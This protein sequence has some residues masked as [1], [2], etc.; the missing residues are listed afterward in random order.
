MRAVATVVQSAVRAVL[1]IAIRV[2]ASRATSL[3]H[4]TRCL[5]LADAAKGEGAAIVF[6]GAPSTADWRNMIET[7][8]H[9]FKFLSPAPSPARQESDG[10]KTDVRGA[11][12]HADWLPWSWRADADATLAALAEMAPADWL[13][14]DH[15][16]LDDRW[17]RKV[18]AG[19]AKIMVVDDLADRPHDC[20]L[21]LDQNAQ[22]ETKDRYAALVP[23]ETRRLIGPRYAL[24]RPQFAAARDRRRR[25]GRVG[26]IQVFMSATDA[27]GASLLVLDALAAGRLASL[28]V[29][30]VIGRACPHLQAIE[31]RAAARGRTIVHVDTDEMARL[32]VDADLAI[33]AGGVAALERCCLGLPSLTL[34]IAANQEAG[35][36]ALKAAGAVRHLGPIK[37]WTAAALSREIAALIGDDRALLSLS[38]NAAALVDGTGAQRCVAAL[39]RPRSPLALR[40]AT[41]DDAR[42]LFSWR[43]DESVRRVSVNAAPIEWSD[44][45][46]WLSGRLRDPNHRH[47][48]GETDGEACGATRFDI[49]EGKAKVSIVVA[50]GRRGEGLGAQLLREGEARLVAT[51]TDVTQFVAEIVPG[52]AASRRLFSRNGYELTGSSD[53]G[54]L[55]YIKFARPGPA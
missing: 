54:L 49:C 50:F 28:P 13:I 8:G 17:E 44:H 10:A 14:V 29:D 51:R 33:G 42:Q 32:G 7:R 16:A 36:F 47:W 30:V 15:Y 21:L 4:L 52:N 46:A 23:A 6:L 5:T 9:A 41:I 24:L 48:I 1:R 34:S 38:E 37:A 27:D 26:R 40:E 45:L 18:R 12:A 31:T 20:H 2:D 22:D 25:D 55:C 19:A 11:P 43:N 39:M 3:G 53:S 35:L